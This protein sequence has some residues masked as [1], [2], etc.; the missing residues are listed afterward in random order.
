MEFC[1]TVLAEAAHRT[2]AAHETLRLSE[3]DRLA[4]FD[5]LIKHY[6]FS[7][8]RAFLTAVQRAYASAGSV[9]SSTLVVDAISEQAATFYEAN[10][11]ARLPES[12]RL[13]LPMSLLQD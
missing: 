5:A 9:G 12:P 13:V 7:S 6:S 8:I 10:G 2:I 11:F 4:F 3:R 1:V